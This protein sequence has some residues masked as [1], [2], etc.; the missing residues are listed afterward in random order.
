VLLATWAMGGEIVDATIVAAL[1]LRNTEVERATVKAGQ[2]P[3]GWAEKPAQLRQKDRSARW[4]V[5]FSKDKPREDGA[6]QV[7]L[8]GPAFG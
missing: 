2:I 5:K 7:D 8:A 6:S 4:R 3:K 1:K